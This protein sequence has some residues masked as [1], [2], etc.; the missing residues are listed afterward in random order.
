[1]FV[2]DKGGREGGRR[3]RECVLKFLAKNDKLNEVKYKEC[4]LVCPPPTSEGRDEKL[5]ENF[6]YAF[7]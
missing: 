4:Y 6:I 2:Y 5:K 3:E 1:V 7:I